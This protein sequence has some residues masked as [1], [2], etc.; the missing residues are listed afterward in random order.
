MNKTT[1]YMLI[2]LIANSFLS[3]FKIT[4]GF[5]SNTKSLIADGIHSF[6]DLTTDILAILGTHISKKPAD[7]EHKRGHGK[8]EYVTSLII[9]IFIVLLGKSMLKNAFDSSFTTPS[10]Y[11]SIVV[12]VTIIT[13]Y[14]V[15]SL[16]IKKGEE[17][18]DMILIS[19]G[20]ESY[21]DVYSSLLVLIVII[22]SQF[23][24]KF[25]FLKYVDMIGTILISIL[26]IIMGIKL[27]IQNL[28][29]LIGEAELS[30]DTLNK[31][32]SII[33]D[34]SEKFILNDCTMFKLGS[35][36]EVNLKILVD[37]KTTVKDGHNLM[38]DIEHDLINSDMNIKYVN[39]HIEP[40]EELEQVKK[41]K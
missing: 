36:Y 33:N 35:Y 37:G 12:L 23:S 27:L 40:L 18:N 20:K 10:I 8:I 31:V 24:S 41:C 29:L 21:T 3:I 39:I 14:L 9:S 15:S 26:I 22:L 25:R 28:S 32:R 2:S 11:L 4:F 30:T 5:L 17:T 1:K 19:S 34:R 16:L 38:D 6:S 13:K 7:N